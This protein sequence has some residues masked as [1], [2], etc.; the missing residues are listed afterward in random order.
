MCASKGVCEWSLSLSLPPPSFSHS[1]M[2]PYLA[3]W[4]ICSACISCLPVLW[5]MCVYMYMYVHTHAHTH[6][7]NR[8]RPLLRSFMVY[9]GMVTVCACCWEN[10]RERE[11]GGRVRASCGIHTYTHIH[12]C[13]CIH[14]W[15]T[16]ILTLIYTH[17]YYEIGCVCVRSMQLIRVHVYRHKCVHVCVHCTFVCG[18]KMFELP[19]RRCPILPISLSLSLPLSFTLTLTHSPSLNFSQQHARTVTIPQ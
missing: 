4:I 8:A 14:T 6:T 13:T 16:H 9:W 7:A 3:T 17:V 2:Q 11:R 12:T 15:N 10:L 18:I 19:P 1:N 5:P